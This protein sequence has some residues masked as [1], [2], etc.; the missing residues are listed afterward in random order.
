MAKELVL[1]GII[2]R[3]RGM[4]WLGDGDGSTVEVIAVIVAIR[5]EEEWKGTLKI[6]KMRL[7]MK[8]GR[9]KKG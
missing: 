7:M 3:L 2:M 6:E 4:Q 9:R 1:E 8:G 5:R